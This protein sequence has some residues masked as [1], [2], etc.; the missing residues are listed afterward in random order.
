M[1]RGD[2]AGLGLVLAVLAVLCTL[3]L[4]DSALPVLAHGEP[5]I[6]GPRPEGMSELSDW[7]TIPM[8]RV[9]GQGVRGQRQRE[10]RSA[11]QASLADM[12]GRDG[13]ESKMA[14]FR[15]WFDGTQEKR[16]SGRVVRGIPDNSGARFWKM[17][18]YVLAFVGA[19]VFLLVCLGTPSHSAVSYPALAPSPFKC[20]CPQASYFRCLHQHVP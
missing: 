5:D 4:V 12:G 13:K 18:P 19:G 10:R 6:A 16:G 8:S 17:V 7:R 15:E 20:T 1:H 14:G 3:Q 2:L 9:R 11:G